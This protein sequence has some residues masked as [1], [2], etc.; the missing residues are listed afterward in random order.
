MANK[1]T[2]VIQNFLNNFTRDHV[3]AAAITPGMLL[4]LTSAN[5]VQA[6]SNAGQDVGVIMFARENL[7]E[8]K[9][10][11][12]NYAA[13][14]EVD[15]WIPQR[16]DIVEAILADGENVSIGDKLESNGYGFLQKYTADSYVP[17]E[18]VSVYGNQIVGVALE[19]IDASDNSS[20]GNLSSDNV[21]DYNRRI[22]VR[23]V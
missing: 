3:A 18:A 11:D 19:A 21:V 5:K 13:D 9:T 20:G 4:E 17:S 14:D 22:Q 7:L 12:D 2:V 15:V 23:I 6:H 10:V 8:G 1:K 16:G